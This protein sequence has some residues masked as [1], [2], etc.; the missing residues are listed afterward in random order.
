MASK[1]SKNTA[2]NPSVRTPTKKGHPQTNPNSLANLKPPWKA[3][4]PSPNP[5]GKPKLLGDSYKE[6]LATVNDKDPQGRTNA[7]LGA[8][9][10]GM[11][12]L[13]GE[14]AAAREIRTA[15]EGENIKQDGTLTIR[16]EWGDDFSAHGTIPETAPATTENSPIE[17]ET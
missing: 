5:S 9:S 16:V 7:Q 15:T 14:V 11:S 3:G 1:T 17:S 13:R 12:M 2:R 6:W 4:D 8:L 10:M